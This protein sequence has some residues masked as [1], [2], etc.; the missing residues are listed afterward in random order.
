[1]PYS[2]LN[3]QGIDGGLSVVKPRRQNEKYGNQNQ[4]SC[5]SA[6]GLWIRS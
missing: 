3:P 5:A 4:R 2:S 6:I 1:M